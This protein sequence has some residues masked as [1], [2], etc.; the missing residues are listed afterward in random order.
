[1]HRYIRFIL[2][3]LCT[4]SLVGT[5]AATDGTWGVTELLG[6]YAER[7]G[8]A[9]AHPHLREFIKPIGQTLETDQVRIELIDAICDDPSYLVAWT[10]ENKTDDVLYILDEQRIDG[11]VFDMV[12]RCNTGQQ[13]I[14][15][16]ATVMAGI[17]ASRRTDAAWTETH[18]FAIAFD[19]LKPLAEVVHFGPDSGI[20][21]DDN[22]EYRAIVNQLNDEGKIAEV[23][24]GYVD[25]GH[26]FGSNWTNDTTYADLYAASDKFE[27][28]DSLQADVSLTYNT[29]RWTALLGG[30]PI[31]KD[32][33]TYTLRVT[34]ASLSP[35][36]MEVQMDFRFPN[37]LTAEAYSAS[38]FE[39]PHGHGWSFAFLDEKGE[40]LSCIQTLYGFGSEYGS[41]RPIRQLDGTYLW[42]YILYM[43]GISSIPEQI[44][45]MPTWTDPSAPYNPAEK[46]IQQYPEQ[47]IT[48]TFLPN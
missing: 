12:F 48:L 28:L 2:A 36:T 39:S 47:A 19:V 14:E 30:E 37:E 4:V 32:N 18:T 25:L 23:G 6:F 35:N 15:P 17:S 20:T 41:E 45:I 16:G 10:I 24:S 22:D 44:A 13:F 29:W 42:S 43:E 1:M 38:M 8:H 27:R 3:L 34:K 33:G 40:E 9:D 46:D 21:W 26:D 11:D 7:C 5:A 31:E